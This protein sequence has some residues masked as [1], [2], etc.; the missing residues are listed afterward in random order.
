MATFYVM[1][2][3]NTGCLLSGNT[4][5]KLGID[6]L[7]LNKFTDSEESTANTKDKAI[8]EIIGKYKGTTRWAS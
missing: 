7:N 1:H 2:E 6:K 8:Q 5:Q 4:A 3:K